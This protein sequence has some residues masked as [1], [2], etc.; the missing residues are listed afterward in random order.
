MTAVLA[1]TAMPHPASSAPP[2]NPAARGG[3]SASRHATREQRSAVR[4]EH[5]TLAW[6]D[7]LAITRE[8]LL[9]RIEL[10]PWPMKR[11]GAGMDSARVKALESLVA[12]RL[13]AEQARR[14]GLDRGNRLARTVDALRKTL[15]RDALYRDITR[16]SA[17][18]TPAEIT[19][20]VLARTRG[21]ASARTAGLRRVVADSLRQLSVGRR[22]RT[23]MELTLE[24]QRAT[25]DSVSLLLL[26][27]SLRAIMATTPRESGGAATGVGEFADLLLDHLSGSLERPLVR[28]ADGDMTLGDC[29]GALRFYP[30]TIHAKTRR[31]FAA[32]LS[33]RLKELVEGERMAREGL[34][35]GL[36]SDRDV[37]REVDRWSTAW[38]AQ[39]MMERAASSPAATEAEAYRWL[40]REQAEGARALRDEVYPVPQA[41]GNDPRPDSV[42]SAG[43]LLAEAR[44]RATASKRADAL[45]DFIAS[46]A[47]R[48]QVR[49]DYTAL[50][51]TTVNPDN[52]VTKRMIGFGGGMVAAPMLVPMWEWVGYWRSGVPRP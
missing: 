11:R 29:I 27:D 38:L 52:M 16:G 50:R 21:R 42:G 15:V 6:V 41:Q 39:T 44:R 34:R 8:D 9:D 22:A 10:M 40:A 12:E 19:H 7:T 32:E 14:E 49:L 28:M 46:L 2:L 5:D 18:P 48:S 31:G 37:T 3:D 35:R 25:V 4:S 47:R 33:A 24:G 43:R 51:A 45:A 26:A 13:L 30:F 23:F 36:A 1:A 17:E 20:A